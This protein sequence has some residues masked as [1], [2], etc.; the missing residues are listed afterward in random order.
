[1]N[2]LPPGMSPLPV[3]S[4][5]STPFVLLSLAFALL[6]LPLAFSDRVSNYTWD[7]ANYH[8]PA[9]TRIRAHWPRLDLNTDSLSA[10]APGYHY[11]LATLSWLTGP[12][13]MAFRLIN[14]GVSWCVLAL[15]WR[16]WP[17]GRAPWQIALCLAP[18]AFSNFFVKS[19]AY[20]VT[21]NAALLATTAALAGLLLGRSTG[22]LW[23]AGLLS[24]VSILI[25]QS[26]AWL[27]APLALRFFRHRPVS[28]AGIIALMLPLAAL[29]WLV[30]SWG[31]L[32]PP[33]WRE[34][35]LIGLDVPLVSAT[36]LLSVFAL[37]GPCFYAAAR[38]ADWKNDIRRT[39]TGVGALA[40]LAL[41]AISPAIPDMSAGRWG[42]YLWNLAGL[43][44]TLGGRSLVFLLLAPLGGATLAVLVRR[45]RI[46]AG[47]ATALL[48]VTAF[49]AWAAA[50]AANRQVFQRYYEPVLLVLLVFWLL[51][52]EWARP[53]QVAMDLRP[54]AALA[55]L[56]LI[57][58]V[59][60]AHARVFG[61]Y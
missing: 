37:F 7:E 31:G 53:E 12:S 2:S 9:I 46:D 8:L 56:Q 54:L 57:I 22:S 32:V 40:G 15:L 14:F 44:P 61:F 60:T 51:Q 25:R 36:Y 13:R 16:C 48:W 19:A 11:F 30:V 27:M 49:V 47:A 38:P 10:T 43:L 55:S 18:L 24:S 4:S 3:R 29:G 42:G 39:G 45:L 28:V 58:T 20:V 21:D 41:A 35:H 17:A 59:A 6:C 50:M 1:M 23:R 5:F 52:R 33:A 34:T 26:G